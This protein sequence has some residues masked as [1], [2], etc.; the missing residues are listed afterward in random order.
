MSLLARAFPLTRLLPV[1]LMAV[2]MQTPAQPP[3]PVLT[4][5]PAVEISMPTEAGRVYQMQA[6]ADLA[7]WQNHGD[8]V[9]GT[10]TP[11]LQPVAVDSRQ[12]FR[13]QV[14][15][16]PA[17]GAA[18]WSIGGT[19]IQLNDSIR[20]VR[21]DFQPG[22][23]G[24]TADGTTS[25]SFTWT[26]LRD[27][28]ACGRVELSF[29]DNIR[30]V[31]KLNYVTAQV[32]QFSRK[33]YSGDRL[34]QTRGGVFGPAPPTPSPLVPALITGRSF[35]FCEQPG[36]NGLTITSLSAGTRLMDGSRTSFNANW[37][38]TSSSTAHL[39]AN[40]SATHGE[41]YRF[42]FTGPLTGRYTRHTFTEGVFRDEDV[43]TF[44]LSTTP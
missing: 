2:P 8:P 36:G 35:A 10:G 13:L 4:L 26:W 42:T 40:F 23:L 27:G 37:L 41:N 22:G 34:D 38:V 6:S 17:I 15:S 7:S 14:L 3:A 1:L 12:F 24:T 18:N 28:P 25:K 5:R 16:T 33:T 31:L 43:G 21:Y 44:S 30:D 39:A 20:V 32:G 29:P 9:F 11:V 19:A